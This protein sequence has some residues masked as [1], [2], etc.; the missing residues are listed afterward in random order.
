MKWL[1][2]KKSKKMQVLFTENIANRQNSFAVIFSR[3]QYNANTCPHLEKKTYS[4]SS[5]ALKRN[6]RINATEIIACIPIMKST[7]FEL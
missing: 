7:M 5:F 3:K 1:R 4:V 2:L 6:A